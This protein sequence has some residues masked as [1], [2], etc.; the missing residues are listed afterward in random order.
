MRHCAVCLPVREGRVLLGLKKRGFGEGKIVEIGGGLEPGETPEEAAIRETREEC[1]LLARNLVDHGEV[2][3]EFTG[4]PQ[5]AIRMR[6][7]VTRD[8]DGE[9]V[10]TDEIRPEWFDVTAPPFARMWADGA[11]VL[12]RVLRGERVFLR[13]LFAEDGE[14]IA[15][16]SPLPPS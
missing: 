16:V 14:T 3:F 8:W 7:F 1:G 13:F 11:H 5:W 4:R 10:E 6:I 2:V 15:S 9:P 12:P